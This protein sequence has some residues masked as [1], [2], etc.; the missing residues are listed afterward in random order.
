MY[1]IGMILSAIILTL[2]SFQIGT[3]CLCAALLTLCLMP[4]AA[5]AQPIADEEAPI[6]F[7]AQWGDGTT[8]EA[9]ELAL[10]QHP[11]KQHGRGDAVPLDEAT[12][13]GRKLFD[14]RDPVRLLR[15]KSVKS[16]LVGP[17][18]E[19]TNGDVLPGTV[20]T[21]PDA[22][23]ARKPRRYVSVAVSD[24]LITRTS[25]RTVPVR[26]D[27]IARLVMTGPTGRPFTP[28]LIVFRDGRE[29]VAQEIKWTSRGLQ[30]LLERSVQAAAW[31]QL[32]EVHV[33]RPDRIGAILRDSTHLP[34]ADRNLLGRMTT[35]IGAVLTHH[36]DRAR[37][38]KIAWTY[39][40]LVQPAWADAGIL[41]PN[42]NIASVAYRRTEEVPLS[43]LPAETLAERNLTGFTWRWR[44]N[45]NV[46][47]GP[48]SVGGRR[49]ALGVGTHSYSE[50]V[51]DLPP[52]AALF[53]SEVGIDDCVR[54][55]GCVRCKV[56][57]DRVGGEPAWAS[58]VVQG[59]EKPL[60]VSVAFRSAKVAHNDSFRSAKVAD[61]HSFRS[62]K[63]ADN[64]SFRSAKEADGRNFRGA[65]GDNERLVLVTEFAD[66]DHPADADPLDIGDAVSWLD[67]TVRVDLPD[68]PATGAELTEL[69][70]QLRHWTLSESMRQRISPRTQ[71]LAKEGRWGHSMVLDADKPADR[72]EPLV[73]TRKIDVG[74]A[75]AWLLASTARDG[76][77]SV[78][79]SLT[80]HADGKKVPGTEGYDS[81]TTGWAPGNLDLVAYS[82]GKYLGKEVELTVTVTPTEND[83]PK[84]DLSGIIW[85]QL[86]LNPLIQG[87]PKT[88]VPIKPDVALEAVDSLKIV[89][90]ERIEDDDAGP[91]RG[92]SPPTLRFAPMASGLDLSPN[93]DRVTCQLDPRWKRFVACIGPAYLSRDVIESFQVW[94]DDE[95]LW[96]SE[97]FTRLSPP[98]QIDVRLPEETAGKQLV[99]QVLGESSDHAVWANAGFV[100]E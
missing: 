72:V 71:L 67:A 30:L 9:A 63:V 73:L 62:A 68:E 19:L 2:R 34:P 29:V 94:V 3:R 100:R 88:G 6:R 18:I 97:R 47:E 80:V 39:Y 13:G 58:D 89:A 28:G 98:Q 93:I 86:T 16:K 10:W 26:I 84:K 17:F 82:L 92:D 7:V 20:V 95:M 24:P 75:N 64:D 32:A 87:L 37:S 91:L 70:P 40:H 96:Q 83:P 56:F 43:L 4:C 99:L 65:K 12:I 41:V 22:D 59:G 15:D 57:L 60:R 48:L 50:I 55:G 42:D 74:L 90:K 54:R 31:G 76:H 66:A 85:G 5:V 1:K 52:G 25:E 78:G 38:T 33:P 21:T 77:G 35:R 14:R 53:S 51:F 45:R 23:R 44:R 81:N 8:T 61:N 79:Y 11:E 46:R 27:A 69:F 49:A 36:L